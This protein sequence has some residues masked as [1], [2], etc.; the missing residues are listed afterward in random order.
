MEFENK[1]KV[2]G[3]KKKTLKYQPKGKRTNLGTSLK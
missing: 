1:V 2:T 3:F